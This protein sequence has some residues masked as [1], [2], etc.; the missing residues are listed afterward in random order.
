M[1]NRTLGDFRTEIGEHGF[2]DLP[3]ITMD[4]AVNNAYEELVALERWPWLIRTYSGL[5]VPGSAALT[6]VPADFADVVSLTIDANQQVL[7][8]MELDE[9]RKRFVG[10]YTDQGLPYLYYGIGGGAVLPNV[11]RTAYVGNRGGGAINQFATTVSMV[12]S[13]T[14][15]PGN[16]IVLSIATDGGN[17][18]NTITAPGLVFDVTSLNPATFPQLIVGYVTCPNGLPGGTTITATFSGNVSRASWSAQEWSGF[19]LTA[20]GQTQYASGTSQTPDSGNVPSIAIGDAVIGAVAFQATSVPTDWVQGSGYAK[21]NT[22]SAGPATPVSLWTEYQVALASGTYHAGATTTLGAAKWVAAIRS[23]AQTTTS[24]ETLLRVHP[25]PDQAYAYVLE[26]RKAPAPL[27]LATDAPLVPARYQRLISFRALS[28]LHAQEDNPQMAQYWE[29]QFMENIGRMREEAWM[30]QSDRPNTILNVDTDDYYLVKD[31]V[32]PLDNT[33]QVLEEPTQTMRFR[34]LP[35]EYSPGQL[36]LAMDVLFQGDGLCRARNG[37]SKYVP[38]MT[39]LSNAAYNYN[40]GCIGWVRQTG[41]L[42]QIAMMV[43]RVASTFEFVLA[44]ASPKFLRTMAPTNHGGSACTI[45]GRIVNGVWVGLFSLSSSSDNNATVPM[46]LWWGG[47]ISIIGTGGTITCTRGSTAVTG[48]GPTG[49]LTDHVGSFITDVTGTVLIGRIAKMDPSGLA[50]TLDRPALA[51]LAGVS[52]QFHSTRNFLPRMAKGRLTCGVGSPVVIG[53]LTKFISGVGAAPGFTCSVPPAGLSGWS[54]FRARD[55]AFVGFVQ[56]FDSDLQ[57]TLTANAAVP[58]ANDRYL[59]MPQAPTSTI[60]GTAMT[61]EGDVG[62]QVNTSFGPRGA[63]GFITEEHQGR[64]Y[65]TNRP[66][67]TSARFGATVWFSDDSDYEAFDLDEVAGDWITVGHVSQPI[68]ALASTQ[69][70]LAIFKANELWMLYGDD[71]VNYQLRKLAN[72]GTMD[73]RSVQSY[74]GNLIFVSTAGVM[75]FDGSTVTNLTAGLISPASFAA[76]ANFSVQVFPIVGMQVGSVYMW[77]MS[78]L[79][80]SSIDALV[81]GTPRDTNA[82]L[83]GCLDLNTGALSVFSNIL[84]NA[85]CQLPQDGQQRGDVAW[86]GRDGT[87]GAAKLNVFSAANIISGVNAAFGSQFGS[88][89][90][91]LQNDIWGCALPV[92]DGAVYTPGPHPYVK[93]RRITLP[94]ERNGY[95]KE[96]WLDYASDDTGIQVECYYGQLGDVT[97]MVQDFFIPGGSLNTN[98]S[99][100]ATVGGRVR[101]RHRS[102]FVSLVFYPVADPLPLTGGNS[103]FGMATFTLHYMMM[104][105]TRT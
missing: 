94:Q 50:L 25:V 62:L 29:S 84:P 87:V 104:R 37:F 48:A 36:E 49:W 70:G 2:G 10:S 58:M 13:A 34:G 28:Y 52:Y 102:K 100:F 60:T 55:G 39:D 17:V 18:C 103:S 73:G 57:L 72:I 44:A 53:A 33:L 79:F 8:P 76:T 64:L 45:A 80:S 83:T 1:A 47:G 20:G 26:Y 5:T 78:N 40:A 30:L 88:Q 38:G 31:L 59:L 85:A 51:S 56:S 67:S 14:V 98:A 71:P 105:R 22:Q 42:R 74:G 90:L 82:Q 77:T 32:P 23:F 46:Q 99:N 86:V 63:G 19:S 96:V 35:Y 9:F 75:Q 16:A 101:L 4:R 97:H 92:N 81:N 15:L 91:T 12:T 68:T 66:D 69:A 65:M 7:T 93:T 6:D 24:G 89:A 27:V 54:L 43:K 95:W 21:D 3:T 61:W 11:V 41:Q